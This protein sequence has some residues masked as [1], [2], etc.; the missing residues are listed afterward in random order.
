ML[1]L[2]LNIYHEYSSDNPAVRIEFLMLDHLKPFRIFY[3]NILYIHWL[4]E[5]FDS[6]WNSRSIILLHLDIDLDG[7]N[8]T[9]TLAIFCYGLLFK[10][11]ICL[12]NN[13]LCH[14]TACFYQNVFAILGT[15]QKYFTHYMWAKWSCFY[16]TLEKSQV[17][18]LYIY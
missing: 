13:N 1:F 12:N 11:K 4:I 16:K 17:K 14:L 10:L 15:F 6:E 3:K 8:Q 7:K 18:K 9:Y 5:I 2:H